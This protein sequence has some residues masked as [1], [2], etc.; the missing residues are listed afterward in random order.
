ML[1]VFHVFVVS[2]FV[3]FSSELLFHTLLRRSECRNA[4]NFSKILKINE[5]LFNERKKK[6][7]DTRLIILFSQFP[8]FNF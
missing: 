2:S 6:S 4:Y 5:G 3:V 1:P 7:Y 8:H